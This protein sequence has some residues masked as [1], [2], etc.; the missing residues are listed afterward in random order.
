MKYFTKKLIGNE[1]SLCS[2]IIKPGDIC[3]TTVGNCYDTF[4]EGYDKNYWFKE[5]AKVS[6]QAVW[7]KEDMEI[8]EED[9]KIL[10]MDLELHIILFEEDRLEDA[11]THGYYQ[12]HKDTTKLVAAIKNH[13]C[14]H[15]H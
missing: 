2:K 10:A 9:I 15:F 13:S 8:E 14:S 3:W 7:I 4:K 12:A 1:L 5:V 11:I 6:K